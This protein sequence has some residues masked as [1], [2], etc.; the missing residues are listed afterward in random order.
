MVGVSTRRR[1]WLR[2]AVIVWA[3]AGCAK[4]EPEETGHGP[5]LYERETVSAVDATLRALLEELRGLSTELAQLSEID[6]VRLHVE[7]F[8]YSKGCKGPIKTNPG[9]ESEGCYVAV[10]IL[11]YHPEK[12]REMAERVNLSA[13][14][15]QKFALKHGYRCVTWVLVRAESTP[16]GKQFEERVRRI[17]SDRLTALTKKLDAKPMG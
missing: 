15:Y 17:V 12:N 4:P 5:D 14:A 10:E 9:F 13:Q 7:G 1:G 16:K 11:T 8:T 3:L 6:G 2:L